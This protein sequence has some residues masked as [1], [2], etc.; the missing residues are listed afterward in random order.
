[1]A[2]RETGTGARG[3]FWMERGPASRGWD[4]SRREV[5]ARP[6][7]FVFSKTGV[8]GALCCLQDLGRTEG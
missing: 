5:W 7:H 3:V 1:M 4:T 6:T 2:C 8:D